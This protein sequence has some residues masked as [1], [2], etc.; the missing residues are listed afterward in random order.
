MSRRSDGTV[1][2]GAGQIDGPSK[3]LLPSAQGQL[4]TAEQYNNLISTSR[5]GWSPIYLKDVAT[6]VVR[7]GRADHSGSGCA[8]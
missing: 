2:T 3:T 5:E 8:A 6:A 1:Y 4:D 7:A